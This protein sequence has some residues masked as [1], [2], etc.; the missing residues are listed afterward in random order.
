MT[1]RILPA[2]LLAVAA[3]AEDANLEHARQVNLERA[4]GMPNFVADEVAKRYRSHVGSTKWT[5]ED[6]IETEITVKGI[7]ISRQ[8][9]RRDG[10]PSSAAEARSMPSTGF[11]TKTGESAR[12]VHPRG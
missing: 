7:R 5:Y 2:A 11:G 1:R 9:W 12:F 6:T 4:G 10:K 3:L 8:N